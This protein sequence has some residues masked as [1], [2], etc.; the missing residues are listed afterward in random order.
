M[1]VLTKGLMT[2]VDYRNSGRGTLDSGSLIPFQVAVLAIYAGIILIG[3]ICLI[4]VH[5]Q[6]CYHNYQDERFVAARIADAAGAGPG[7]PGGPHS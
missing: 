3:V 5:L 1:V 7:A 4:F 6:E 2:V